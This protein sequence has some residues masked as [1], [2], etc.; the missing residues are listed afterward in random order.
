MRLESVNFHFWPICNFQCKYCFAQFKEI[1]PNLSKKHCFKIIKVLSESGTKKISFAGGEPTLS[2]FLGDLLIYSKKLGLT[3]SL[4][5]NGTGI[6]DLFAKKYEK[7][8]DWIGL[9]IDSGIEMVNDLLG[10]G[11]NLVGKIIDK[12]IKISESSIKLKINTVVNRLNFQEDLSWLIEKIKPQRWKVFQILEIKNQAQQELS[13]LLISNSEFKFF[14]ERHQFLKPIVENNN[15]MLESYLMIDPC[16]RF[17][18]NTG[19]I[20]IFSRPILEV[21]LE[22]ALGDISFDFVKFI[23]RGGLYAW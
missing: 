11:R 17:Y 10:R 3:N 9:S 19:N 4:I 7:Y 15:T 23:E 14:V 20:Y 16:G 6:N 13:K 2:P 8:L 21:G 22:N 5:S 12:A 1:R 18:Q